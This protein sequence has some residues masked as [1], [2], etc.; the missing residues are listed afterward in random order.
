MYKPRKYHFDDALNRMRKYCAYQE[1]CVQECKQKLYNWGYWGDEADLIIN[2]LFDENYLDEGRFAVAYLRGKFFYKY[3]GKQRIV[4]E[5][6][7]R[8]ISAYNIKL[9]LKEI[10]DEAYKKAIMYLYSKKK[11]DYEGKGLKQYQLNIK[12][13]N[14]IVQKGYEYNIVN[15]LIGE[16]RY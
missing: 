12:I 11:K 15:E 16:D 7:S 13:K 2:Q 5:L 10:S 1:R 6:K 9:A 4:F 14:F 3:W 8:K